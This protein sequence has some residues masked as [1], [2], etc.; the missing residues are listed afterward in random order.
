MARKAKLRKPRGKW[1]TLDNYV[2]LIVNMNGNYF[3][4]RLRVES[5]SA[6]LSPREARHVANHIL[7]C[8]DWLD[9]QGARP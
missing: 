8:C 7:K 6:T 5:N 4:V 3:A 2:G 9:Q 1:L